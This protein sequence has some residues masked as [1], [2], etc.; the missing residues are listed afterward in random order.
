[1]SEKCNF[2]DLLPNDVE[3]LKDI[4]EKEL[5]VVLRDMKGREFYSKVV[6]VIEEGG[7]IGLPIDQKIP[8]GIYLVTAT[9][10]NQIYSQKLIIR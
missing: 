6:I 5:L 8:S 4:I 9:S 7:F 10:E 2:R 3:E 1:M